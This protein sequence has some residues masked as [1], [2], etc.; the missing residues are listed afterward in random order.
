[1]IFGIIFLFSG[2]T[3]WWFKGHPIMPTGEAS[4]EDKQIWYIVFF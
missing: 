1:M 3:F 4:V 2:R